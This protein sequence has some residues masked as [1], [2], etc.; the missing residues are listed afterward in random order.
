[1]IF[2]NI[3]SIAILFL[4]I[5]S[6][7]FSELYGE[8]L[9]SASAIPSTTVFQMQDTTSTFGLSVF[10]LRPVQSEFVSSTSSLI[11][12]S[13]DTIQVDLRNEGSPTGTVQVGVFNPD[14]SVKQ[15]FGTIDAST[16]SSSYTQYTFSL[17][18]PQTYLVHSGDRIGVKF[19]GGDSSNYVA[20]MTDQNNSFDGKKSYL[21]YFYSGAWTGFRGKDLTMNLLL[22][23]NSGSPNPIPSPGGTSIT[24]SSSP[25]AGT[26]TGPQAV[27]L[28][29]SAPSTIYYTTDGSTP[30][31]SNTNGPSPLTITVGSTSI[32]KFFA[33]DA[34]NNIGSTSSASYT[35]IPL[36]TVPGAPTGLKATP[37]NTKISLSWTAPASNGGSP[38]TDYVVEYRTGA[39]PIYR[40]CRW[41]QHINQCNCNRP[42]KRISIQFQSI[43]SK[44]CRYQVFP[45]QLHHQHQ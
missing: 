8:N 23:V 29:A 28:T 24:V 15:L 26:Y 34:S 16:L 41:Y 25:P 17:A 39:N 21:S 18:S 27:S 37:S 20:V 13:I 3:T 14:R 2:R 44:L 36:P 38:I 45:Q 4:F 7:T 12:K 33:K 32:L 10:S 35:I 6:V 43:S 31:T 1:M 42:Y 19:T 40:I 30:T 22:H 5:T 9:F 11:G